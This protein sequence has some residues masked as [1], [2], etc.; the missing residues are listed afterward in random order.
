[1]VAGDKQRQTRLEAVDFPVAELR[2]CAMPGDFRQSPQRR[3]EGYLPQRKHHAEVGEQLHFPHQVR[4]AGAL[5]FGGGAVLGRNAA[6]RG[7]DVYA[8]VLQAIVP[9]F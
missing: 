1:M 8:R 7:A 2:S 5:F 6:Y 9:V 3:L 4:Q